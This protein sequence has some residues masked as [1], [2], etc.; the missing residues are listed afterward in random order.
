AVPIIALLFILGTGSV[1]ALVPQTDIDLVSPIP[2]TITIGFQGLGAVEA[3]AKIL[4]VLLLIRQIGNGILLFAGST[5]LPMV[6]GWDGLLPAWFTRLDP[7]FRTPTN[8]IL[9]VGV[10]SIALALAG[11]M[12]V[13]VQEAF[14]L[15]ENCGGIFYAFAYLALF[16]I[17]LVAAARLSER[18]PL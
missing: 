2:Q 10:V 6:A 3:V 8:S 18:P 1:L 7:R 16:A 9:F 17:P 11:Q 12:G 15:L 5:R 13:G 4:I 14:Q